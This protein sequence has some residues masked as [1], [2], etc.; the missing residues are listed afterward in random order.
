MKE[1]FLGKNIPFVLF[2]FIF[3]AAVFFQLMHDGMF[4]DAMLYSSV[5][6][7]LANGM[8]TF[9]FPQFGLTKIGG[10]DAFHEHPPLV[11]AIQSVFF[12]ILGS[13]IF[14][15]RFYTFLMLIFTTFF[16]YKI[17]ISI[18]SEQNEY[19]SL[20][21]LPIIF[22]ITIPVILW[23]F[24]NNM[25]EN[26]MGIFTI[27]SV[28]LSYISFKA[29]KKV[30][31]WIFSGF[32][33]VLATLSKGIPGFFPLAV[34]F[35]YWIATRQIS[36]KVALIQTFTMLSVVILAYTVLFIVPESGESLRVYIFKRLLERVNHA[37]T[38]SSHLYSLY[39]IFSELIPAFFIL[40]LIWIVARKNKFEYSLS[41]FYKREAIFFVLIGF[42]ASVPLML[43]LVQKGFYLTPSF[44]YFSIGIALFSMPY[45][46]QILEK[47]NLK[48]NALR[49]INFLLLTFILSILIFSFIEK[50]KPSRDHELLKDVYI[51]GKTIDEPVI[52]A[53]LE[54]RTNWSLLCYMVRY[55]NIDMEV[56]QKH[57]YLILE[58]NQK[59][60][61]LF[62][63]E[64]LDL[65]T[66]KY[67][68]YIQKK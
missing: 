24:S 31:F 26:T 12:K 14:V 40:I 5:S 10:L 32:L 28:L 54:A 7:N 6:H 63:F 11:F 27:A 67:D 34:P 9:W 36:F 30:F 47:I 65:E 64:K 25:Q 44:P 20:A 42:S 49:Y 52:S 29:K 43:T 8:G 61:S 38:V 23:T 48:S 3:F 51:F 62:K 57:K 60:D 41:N 19:K 45:I 58:K 56:N 33:I 17:W 46:K 15:E 1:K 66:S 18:H 53:S 68:L 2:I 16:I 39:R 59:T 55:F 35:L 13:S 21:W 37:P 50:G 4:M 22:W